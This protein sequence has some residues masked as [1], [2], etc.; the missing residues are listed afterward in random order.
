MKITIKNDVTTIQNLD[1]KFLSV[2]SKR[3][4]YTDKSKQY[5]LKRISKTIWG[6]TSAKA[7]QLKKEIYQTLL[8]EN[9][10]GSI[11]FPTSL[12]YL[13]PEIN[14]AND[15]T[16]LR[17]STG[18]K[19]SLPWV[20]KP[21]ILRPYQEESKSIME[22]NDRGVIRLATGL[23]KTEVAVH[24]IRSIGKNTLIVCPNK[25]IAHQFYN[26]LVYHFGQ[27]KVGLFGDGKK[28]IKELTVGISQSVSNHV[29]LLK[30]TNFG[31]I[32]IDEAHHTPSETLY[33][34][35]TELSSA[36]KIFGLTATDFRSD[37]KDLLISAS[38]GQTLI[39]LD[40]KWGI[41]NGWLAEPMFIVRKVKTMGDSHQDDK[42]FNYRNHIL[43]NDLMKSTIQQDAASFL[44]KGK[45]V[46]I[47]VDEI[48]HGAELS[49]NLN[50]PFATGE[51][52]E[53]QKYIEDFNAGRIQ[54]LIATDGK[55]GEGVDTKPTEVLILANFVASKGPVLQCVG[56]G[57][58]KTATKDKVI[59]LDYIP[60]GSRQLN[61]HAYDRISY[62]KELTNNIHIL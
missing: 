23:G 59:I 53:S 8:T 34:V 46:L 43:N 7:K 54:G 61:R 25:S 44:S 60:E 11:S 47:L 45:K 41:D 28:Q 20:N 1:Q 2:I 6:K 58:R 26:V 51:D 5:Q 12:I 33:T 24:A 29:S 52:R 32:I 17:C 56:R 57:L 14:A 3:L 16:D 18:S 36:S 21:N 27:N 37:G 19:V 31:F 30:N 50:L 35:M 13:F 62:F 9:S 48:K 10:D 42:L 15:L 39:N 38:C 40:A 49:A 55:V 4:S 22:N